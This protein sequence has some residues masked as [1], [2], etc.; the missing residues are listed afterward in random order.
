MSSTQTS[1][2]SPPNKVSSLVS[3]G[4]E[5]TTFCVRARPLVAGVTRRGYGGSKV[6]SEAARGQNKGQFSFVNESPPLP[7]RITKVIVSPISFLTTLFQVDLLVLCKD[8][9]VPVNKVTG[10]RYKKQLIESERGK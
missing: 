3:A 6:E 5:G 1:G 7:T 9:P 8:R 4:G 2:L 10:P